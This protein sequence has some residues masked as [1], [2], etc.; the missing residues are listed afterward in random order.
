MQHSIALPGNDEYS[1]DR[2]V[3]KNG[4]RLRV[5]FTRTIQPR[6]DGLETNAEFERRM[7]Q[8]AEQLASMEGVLGVEYAFER[9]A[10]HIAQ[11][12]IEVTQEPR[13]VAVLEDSRPAGGH[14]GAPRGARGSGQHRHEAGWSSGSSSGS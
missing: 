12:V 14:F 6:K 13:P 11:C 2:F 3:Y 5:S 9:R 8:L 7:G 1:F 10:G 4:Q